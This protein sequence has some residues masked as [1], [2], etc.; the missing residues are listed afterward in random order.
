M[1]QNTG[2]Y[3]KVLVRVFLV[4][5]ERCFGTSSYPSSRECLIQV[6]D[7]LE[8]QPPAVVRA[9]IS[10]IRLVPCMYQAV[11]DALSSGRLLHGH[12]A[13]LPYYQVLVGQQTN[14][15]AVG[16]SQAAQHTPSQHSPSS[17]LVSI[18]EFKRYDMHHFFSPCPRW[19]Y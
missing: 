15:T 3:E 4:F 17:H 13:Y 9:V 19:P 12:V 2:R 10:R 14:P 7:I 11:K 5:S 18:V 16:S 8:A 6:S 1:F